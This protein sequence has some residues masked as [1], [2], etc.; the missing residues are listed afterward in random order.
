MQIET[1][2]NVLLERYAQ[3]IVK[4]GMNVQEG[5]IVNLSAEPYH[6]QLIAMIAEKAYQAGAK[7]VISDIADP[8]LQ[9]LRATVG[10]AQYLEFVPEY[11]VA[12]YRELVDSNAASMRLDG[13][14]DPEVFVGVDTKNINLMR[15]SLRTAASYYYDQGINR[16]KVQW[17]VAAAATPAWARRVFPEALPAEAEGLLWQEI[18]R[19]CRVDNENFLELWN[20]HDLRLHKR[21]K[22]L[23]ELGIRELHFIGPKTDLRVGLSE[24]ARF[25]GG[26][27]L[28]ALGVRF[29]PNMP[30]EEV[31]T[32]PDWRLTEGYVL[33]T[34]PIKVNGVTVRDLSLVFQKGELI[35]FECSAGREVFSEYIGSDSGAKRL[36]EVALVGVDSPVFK[37]GRLFESILLDENAAC[38]IALG[39]AYKDCLDSGGSLNTQELAQCGCN[40][41]SAHLDMM[42]SDCEV[43]VTAELIDGKKVPLIEKG[44]WREL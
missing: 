32:T 22:E 3:L 11:L 20:E 13:P 24:R 10:K 28:S 36:G 18:F 5:Q 6:R 44:Q 4:H 21:R 8:H 9:R 34:R 12:K 41:S 33:V 19:L 16:S 17:L 25:K 38:H 31:Y 26:S 7:L 43:S 15:R 29:Q 42:I 40:E 39:M 30:T 23:S 14:E 2:Q 27:D 37:S 35:S 1:P